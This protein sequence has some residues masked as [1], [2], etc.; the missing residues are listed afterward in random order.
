MPSGISLPLKDGFWPFVSS[1]TVKGVIYQTPQR[2]WAVSRLP[3]KGLNWRECPSPSV[4][5][6]VGSSI[7]GLLITEVSPAGK[8]TESL[9]EGRR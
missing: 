8:W 4:C 9:R 1:V 7:P 5:L 3:F 2:V 6:T